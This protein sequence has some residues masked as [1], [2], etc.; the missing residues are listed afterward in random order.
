MVRR[1]AA[2]ARAA[3]G[4][5][6][7]C[8]ASPAGESPVSVRAGAPSSRPQASGGDPVV[9]AGCRKPVR[10]R[11]P[12]GGEQARGPQHQ[13]KPAASTEEQSGSRAAHVTA[14]ATFGAGRVPE[15]ASGPGGVRGAARGQGDVRN[16]RGPSRRPSSRRARPYKPKAKSGRVERESEGIVVPSITATNN[17]VGGKGPWGGCV[18]GAGK[19]EG[20]AGKTGPNNPGGLEPR[21]KV[22]QPQRRLWAAAKR[23]QG[24]RFQ[25]QYPISRGDAREW[26]GSVSAPGDRVMQRP[27]RPPV[28]RVREIRTHG[29]RGGL[30]FFRRGDTAKG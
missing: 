5:P 24:R 12:C 28:S 15:P 13:V 3:S 8:C 17:A 11:E 18:A 25:V 9:Q 1:E 23:F 10:R 16:T 4:E 14:K 30:D 19:R 7:A 22:R 29:L 2:G 6:S 26:P 27:E 21:G 20:M